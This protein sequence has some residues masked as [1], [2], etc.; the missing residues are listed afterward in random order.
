MASLHAGRVATSLVATHIGMANR[1]FA[2]KVH[3][4][5]LRNTAR[6]LSL[7]G[8]AGTAAAAA[9]HGQQPTNRTL[10]ALGIDPEQ[11][12]QIRR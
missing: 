10:E 6:L 3:L 4:G 11:Y 8:A 2:M 1:S 5:F 9:R 7:F 12:R